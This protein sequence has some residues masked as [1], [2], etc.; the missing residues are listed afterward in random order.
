MELSQAKVLMRGIL[1]A[2]NTIHSLD[3]VHRDMKPD[4]ILVNLSE[5]KEITSVKLAD[6]GQ[7]KMLDRN[8]LINA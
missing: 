1:Q 7:A 3:I 8:K 2:L 6:F 4:N 5:T